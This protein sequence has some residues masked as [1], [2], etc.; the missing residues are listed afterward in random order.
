MNRQG[1]QI[2]AALRR[3]VATAGHDLGGLPG[4][5]EVELPAQL[6]A[7]S[8]R[9]GSA[10]VRLLTRRL[11]G[12]GLGA[13]TIAYMVTEAE[14]L[15]SATVIGMPARGSLL[16]I[17]GVDVIAIG[18]TL[19]LVALDLAPTDEASFADLA[20]PIL[21]AL[22]E[23]TGAALVARK[24]PPFTAGVFSDL[25]LIAAARPGQEE[26]VATA[27]CQF[28]RDYARLLGNPRPLAADPARAAAADAR[29]HSYCAAEIRNRKEHDALAR[30]FGAEFARLYLEG[31]LFAPEP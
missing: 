18:G 2:D 22:H 5:S 23:Q 12:A 16:P 20:A 27:T 19:S 13:L 21:R 7:H 26:L 8:G 14:T 10:P 31:F 6:A 17:L 3:I 25:A 30:L 1:N 4:L 24:R 11:A 15:V 9:L 28:L 29:R